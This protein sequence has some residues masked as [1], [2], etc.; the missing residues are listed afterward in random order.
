MALIP[1]TVGPRVTISR[2]SAVTLAL[3]CCLA[4]GGAESQNPTPGEPVL[5]HWQKVN[6]LDQLAKRSPIPVARAVARKLECWHYTGEEP[7][8]RERRRELLR[9]W[10]RLRC[11]SLDSDMSALKRRYASDQNVIQ[12]LESA[13]ALL[14]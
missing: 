3:A 5:E 7:Y 2:V 6:Q 9:A 11:D 4:S 14:Q 1:E 12:L 10:R 8:D 13:E